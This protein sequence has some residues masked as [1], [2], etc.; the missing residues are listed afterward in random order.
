MLLLRR[1]G[2]F[3]FPLGRIEVIG[4]APDVFDKSERHSTKSDHYKATL[5]I[6]RQGDGLFA[7]VADGL[8]IVQFHTGEGVCIQGLR[9]GQ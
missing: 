3:D 5:G 8:E 7:Q 6:W 4:P 1:V 2:T 9:Q